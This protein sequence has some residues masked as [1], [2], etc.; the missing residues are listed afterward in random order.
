M[1]RVITANSSNY[2]KYIKGEYFHFGGGYSRPARIQWYNKFGEFTSVTG[3]DY[4]VIVKAGSDIND[5]SQHSIFVDK[6]DNISDDI[7]DWN[8]YYYNSEVLYNSPELMNIIET[9]G[10][11]NEFISA[12][13]DL[14]NGNL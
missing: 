13:Y 9:G 1:K 11:V 6:S 10:K 7:L 8:A 4:I 5:P 14:H 12:I 3:K 2:G